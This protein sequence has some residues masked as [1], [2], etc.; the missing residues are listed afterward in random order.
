MS[1]VITGKCLCGSV[2]ITAN[3]KHATFDACHCRMCRTWGGGPVMTIEGGDL[4]K[5]EGEEFVSV[6][7]SSDWAERGF[8]KNCGTHLFYRLKGKN[9]INFHAGLFKEADHFKF[10]VQIYVDA[11]P[12]CYDFANQTA[13]MTEAE[14][15]AMFSGK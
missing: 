1:T 5:I 12:S 4:S 9:F 14:V 6:F 13:M 10:K 3:P 2:T 7:N 8:C 15:I 11:K